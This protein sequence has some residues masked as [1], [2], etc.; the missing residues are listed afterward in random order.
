MLLQKRL[1]LLPGDK[2]F[3]LHPNST[4]KNTELDWVVGSNGETTIKVT[5]EQI[6]GIKNA[7]AFQVVF[8]VS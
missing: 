4:T 5:D 6:A 7:W 8:Q 2:M 3:L 1:P